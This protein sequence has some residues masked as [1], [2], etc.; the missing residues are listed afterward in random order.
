MRI[1]NIIDQQYSWR[2]SLADRSTTD[3]IILHHAAVS[4]ASPQD[5][6]RMHLNNGWTGIGYHFYVAKDGTVYRG[7]PLNSAGAQCQGYN[8]RSIGI[9]A[10]GNYQYEI[11]PEAQKV[12]IA[13]LLRY[14]TGLYPQAQVVGHRDLNA[15]ACPGTNYPFDEIVTLAR[16]GEGAEMVRYQKLSDI[17]NDYGFRE[18]IETLMNAKIINGDGSDQAGNDDVIDLSHDQV[19]TLVFLYRGGAFDRKLIKEGI[20]PAVKD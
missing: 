7:R 10:E 1:L 8:D 9:C 15:T 14:V 13:E 4:A 19:R 5:I 11:M 2:D 6:H 16:E 12:A 17:P 3:Y 18:V 20:Q